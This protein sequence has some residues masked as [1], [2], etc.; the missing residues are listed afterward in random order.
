[1]RLH[2]PPP[3]DV[4][5]RVHRQAAMMQLFDGDEL[6]LS[7]TPRAPL[8]VQ[9]PELDW[10]AAGAAHASQEVL[11]QHAAPTCVV[12]GSQRPDGLR[13]YPG[14]IDDRTVAMGWIVPTLVR[15]ADA[16]AVD[17]ALVWAALDCPGAWSFSGAGTDFFPALLNHSV[18]VLAP[19]RPGEEL[20]VLGWETAREDRKLH[21]ATALTDLDGTPRAVG[22]QTCYAMDPTWAR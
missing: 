17:D 9:I 16:E 19:V 1:V 13:I 3:I 4:T 14:R 7:V 6:V 5:L 21:A 15:G 11:A 2:K 20:L 22:T 12:C 8:S 18:D 10:T